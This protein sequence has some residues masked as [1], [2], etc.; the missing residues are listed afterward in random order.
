MKIK[1]LVWA[2]ALMVGGAIQAAD[3]PDKVISLYDKTVKDVRV[4][5]FEN[6]M[7]CWAGNS[8]GYPTNSVLVIDAYWLRVADPEFAALNLEGKLYYEDEALA[9][10]CE[11]MKKDFPGDFVLGTAR[12]TATEHYGIRYGICWHWM[13]EHM[14]FDASNGYHFES[15]Y[16]GLAIG[17]AKPEMCGVNTK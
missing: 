8:G 4:G 10:R 5:V 9:D 1:G 2:L 14:F 13:E 15:R 16:N 6:Q 3:I 17:P 7:T 12:R 11:E